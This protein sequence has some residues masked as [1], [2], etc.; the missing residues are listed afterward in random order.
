MSVKSAYPIESMVKHA[1]FHK[2]AEKNIT[3]KTWQKPYKDADDRLIAR[4]IS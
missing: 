4:L 3:R 1:N 2:K